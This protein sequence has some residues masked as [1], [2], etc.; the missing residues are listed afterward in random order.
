MC[1]VFE[2]GIPRV[3]ALALDADG[4]LYYSE[5]LR[6]RRGR[7]VRRAADGFRHVALA[8]L[9]KP[10][11]LLAYRGGIA[12]SQEQ[13]E[14]PLHWLH[15]GKITTLFTGRNVEGLSTNGHYLYAIEDDKQNGRILRYDPDSRKLAVLRSGLIEGE[16]IAVC[17]DGNIFYAEK[18]R[19]RI[20]RLRADG[21]SQVI[22]QDL[23]EPG[24]LFCDGE[25][26]WITEDATHNARLMLLGPDG[27]LRVIARRLRAAQTFLPLGGGRF[28][29]AEQ[30]RNRILEL[31]RLPR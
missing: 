21:Q 12:I 23:N 11:G 31:E 19:N 4:G 22:R 28:L 2:E 8:G 3:S 24:F 14:F 15:D 17:P 26:L 27:D 25:G 5:E 30:G 20:V 1:R 16:G 10:D 18:G 7:I 6:N 9:S 13:G 29:L